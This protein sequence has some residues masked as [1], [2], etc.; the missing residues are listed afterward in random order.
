MT[1]NVL[2]FI[3]DQLKK[4]EES[5]NEV[6]RPRDCGSVDRDGSFDADPIWC[7]CDYPD[8]VRKEVEILRK[9]LDDIFDYERGIDWER[10]CCHESPEIRD[11]T[12]KNIPLDEIPA[13][14][15]MAELWS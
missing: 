15:H 10:G 7:S 5:A 12:C 3:E 4:T 8:Q 14:Q 13:L 9:L 6:H 2:Q 11:G 1:T